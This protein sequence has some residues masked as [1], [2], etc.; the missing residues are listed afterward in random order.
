M[1]IIIIAKDDLVFYP[2]TISLINILISQGYKVVCVGRYS[3]EPRKNALEKE[4]VEFVSIYRE[5]KDSA[6]LRLLNWL[7]ILWR[8]KQYQWKMK[9]Y[10]QS[11]KVGKDDLIWFIYSNT[12]G[13]LQ[14]YLE[15][16]KYI[17]QFY[18]FEDYSLR[19]KE[20]LLHPK[21]D[22]HRLFSN[23]KALVHCEY[24]RAMITNG[25]YGIKKEP[26]ILP[27]KPFENNNQQKQSISEEIVKCIDVV[28]SKVTNKKVILYQGIFNP[29]ERRLDEFCEAMSLLPEEYVFIAMGGGGGY[30]NEVKNKYSSDRI[31]F[32]PFIKPPYH[33]LITQ[34]AN[35]G[36]L[37]YHP[38]SQNYVD[39]INPLYC[40]PNK[41]FEFGQYGIPMIAN[42]VPGLKLI[43]DTYN[44][45]KIVSY[46]VTPKKI[47]E[48]IIEMQSQYDLM[49]K[50][51]RAYYDSVDVVEIVNNVIN[52]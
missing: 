36:I 6:K 18:E 39:V 48:T 25:L 52:S 2:P 9:K 1:K 37:T 10:L 17:V 12:I 13:Y 30:F 14:K 19:G 31:I 38:V 35:Y 26:F 33:L 29:F 3:D 34:L 44:C 11:T 42:D 51:S 49:S 21:Y 27:N 40:A 28:K 46:P 32:I 50:G 15:K 43:F 47:A 23:A 5:I 45:G 22:V 41:I 24:N 16:H 7:V 20:K 4:G 8:M